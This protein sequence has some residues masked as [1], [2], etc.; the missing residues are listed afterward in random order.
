MDLKGADADEVARR[1][2]V[3]PDT[4]WAIWRGDR[5]KHLNDPAQTGSSQRRL[6][7]EEASAIRKLM[8]HESPEEIAARYGVEVVTIL[9]VWRGHRH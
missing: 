4:V 7:E 5:W 6:S 3:S 2:H 9:N 1:Y 8:G